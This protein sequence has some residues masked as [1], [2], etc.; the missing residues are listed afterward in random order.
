MG[1]GQG[2][3]GLTSFGRTVMKEQ[4]EAPPPQSPRSDEFDVLGNIPTRTARIVTLELDAAAGGQGRPHG[5][6][7]VRI[8]NP[9]AGD[10]PMERHVG[11]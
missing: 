10:A 7:T 6:P 3:G 1:K 8:R 2:L 9:Y 11:E 5:N 4:L